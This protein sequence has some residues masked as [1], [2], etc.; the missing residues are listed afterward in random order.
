LRAKKSR[1]SGAR[2]QTNWPYTSGSL[3]ISIASMYRRPIPFTNAR[4]SAAASAG[5]PAARLTPMISRAPS[6]C[7][8]ARVVA[9]QSFVSA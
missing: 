4:A 9:S 1:P 8:S 5:R 6:C 2:Y 3:P 7:T